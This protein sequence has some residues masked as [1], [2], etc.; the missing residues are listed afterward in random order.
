MCGFKTGKNVRIRDTGISFYSIQ[1]GDDSGLFGEKIESYVNTDQKFGSL[2][3]GLNS[4]TG[5][6]ASLNVCNLWDFS[7]CLERE[8]EFKDFAV[9][10]HRNKYF[11]LELGDDVN[12]SVQ[13]IVDC[14]DQKN[15]F[16]SQIQLDRKSV[17]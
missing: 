3:V 5:G 17:V 15:Q 16:F 13:E 4:R 12:A 1:I 9:R 6:S 8:R 7:F 11:N 2:N 14:F 10:Y